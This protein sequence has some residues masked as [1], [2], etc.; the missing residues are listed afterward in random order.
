MPLFYPLAAV[1]HF[2]IF[3]NGGPRSM[4]ISAQILKH[5][6]IKNQLSSR[7]KRLS[8]EHAELQINPQ[9]FPENLSRKG[10]YI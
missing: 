4:A 10:I 3:Q 8:K 7:M 6:K 5:P 9:S 1:I 2:A